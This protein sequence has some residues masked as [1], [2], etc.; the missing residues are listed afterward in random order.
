MKCRLGPTQLEEQIAEKLRGGKRGRRRARRLG[1]ARLLGHRLLHEADGAVLV[2]SRMG[3]PRRDLQPQDLGLT[4]EDLFAQTLGSLS[5]KAEA[6]FCVSGRLDVART[7]RAHASGEPG[8]RLGPREAIPSQGRIGPWLELGRTCPVVPLEGVSGRNGREVER[9]LE[10]RL[11]IGGLLQPSHLLQRSRVVP[12]LQQG[13]DQM[14]SCLTPPRDMA[15]MVWWRCSYPAPSN[16]LNHTSSGTSSIRFH[17]APAV[18]QSGST[19]R[20]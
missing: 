13:V 12:D 3:E 5:E 17:R 11:E 19:P 20:R 6:G 15:E 2:G 7:D 10:A 9:R 18:L 1:R 14:M 8:D 4:S 16:A